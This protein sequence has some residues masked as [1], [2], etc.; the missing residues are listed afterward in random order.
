MFERIA[1]LLLRWNPQARRDS[2]REKRYG[3][4]GGKRLKRG[5]KKKYF[6][7]S[8]RPSMKARTFSGRLI[9]QVQEER[10]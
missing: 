2:H 10:F 4:G 9:R 1:L 6:S 3:K 5:K 8:Q 7:Q